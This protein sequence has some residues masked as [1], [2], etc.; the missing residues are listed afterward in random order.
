MQKYLDRYRIMSS[1]ELSFASLPSK[2]Q[3][4]S[5]QAGAD[6]RRFLHRYLGLN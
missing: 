1:P 2:T 4:L 6:A 3:F 5:G